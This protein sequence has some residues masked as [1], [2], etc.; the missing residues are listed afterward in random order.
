MLKIYLRKE[1]TTDEQLKSVYCPESD[2][3]VIARKKD[4]CAYSDENAQEFLG[5]WVW[6]H[7]G[8]PTKS[9]KQI[10]YN[11]VLREIV[12]LEDL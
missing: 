4:V 6:Y 1:T 5:R 3:A 8:K 10:V 7:K 11:S 2:K 12:W 9:V